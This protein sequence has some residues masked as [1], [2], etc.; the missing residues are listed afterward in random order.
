MEID[1][2]YCAEILAEETGY[3]CYVE[4]V[5]DRAISFRLN[6]PNDRVLHHTIEVK[7]LESFVGG[8]EGFLRSAAWRILEQDL[9]LG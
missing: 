2:Q 4:A 9:K 3:P 7:L 5:S 6:L 8:V 1:P